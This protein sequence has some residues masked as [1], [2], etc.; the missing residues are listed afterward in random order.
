MRPVH[1]GEQIHEHIKQ[2]TCEEKQ[3]LSYVR[4]RGEGERKLTLRHICNKLFLSLHRNQVHNLKGGGLCSYLP[5][6]M[7]WLQLGQSS[8]TGFGSWLRFC[9]PFQMPSGCSPCTVHEMSCYHC[10]DLL[11]LISTDTSC[12]ER[13]SELW[14]LIWEDFQAPVPPSL[15]AVAMEW[16]EAQDPHPLE[17]VDATFEP[18]TLHLHLSQV[19]PGPSHP[20]FC[21]I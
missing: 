15:L 5:S 19:D 3:Y 8:S 18:N 12:H 10:H 1:K 17:N 7:G 21:I 16:E 11:L 6:L 14:L 13:F 2:T 20:L 9:L 4:G